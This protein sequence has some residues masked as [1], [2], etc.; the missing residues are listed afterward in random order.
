MKFVIYK[1]AKGEWRWRLMSSNG[2]VM[3]D[4]GEGY[5]TKYSAQKGARKVSSS[6]RDTGAYE[7][8]E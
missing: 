6:L 3:A 5:T 2:R 1:D 8:V 7:V 4:S